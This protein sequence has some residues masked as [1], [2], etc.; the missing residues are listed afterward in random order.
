MQIPTHSNK[1]GVLMSTA[2]LKKEFA[3]IM[4]L[5][6]Q[7]RGRKEAI[8]LFKK[9]NSIKKRLH[10]VETEQYLPHNG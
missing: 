4:L 6:D 1:A 5:A 7:A 8:G 10:K 2:G 3:E 9:A